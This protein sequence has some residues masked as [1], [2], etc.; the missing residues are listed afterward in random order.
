MEGRQMRETGANN[1]TPSSL[2]SPDQQLRQHNINTMNTCL[3]GLLMLDASLASTLLEAIPAE[4][5]N[6]SSLS[7]ARRI[8]A[9]KRAPASRALSNAL[10]GSTRC[11]AA[12]Y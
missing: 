8:A 1:A 10:V 11:P 2:P 12:P 5:V 4:T 7:T 9:V 6:P 3:F